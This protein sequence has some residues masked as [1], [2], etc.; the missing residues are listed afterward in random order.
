[1][2]NL[3]ALLG[4]E[5]SKALTQGLTKTATPIITQALTPATTNIITQAATPEIATS[6]SQLLPTRSGSAI[7]GVIN[8]NTG[9]TLPNATAKTFKDY[10]GS[11]DLASAMAEG[12]MDVSDLNALLPSKQ[13]NALRSGVADTVTMYS[14]EYTGELGTAAT[15]SSLPKIRTS[16]YYK[17]TGLKG[18]DVPSYMK[19]YLSEKNGVSLNDG[20]TWSEVFPDMAQQ[21]GAGSFAGTADDILARYEQ[22]SGTNA[23]DIYTPENYVN[24]LAL[25]PEQ[26]TE[27]TNSLT[28]LLGGDTTRIPVGQT[29]TPAQTIPV[30]GVTTTE[31]QTPATTAATDATKAATDTTS[32]ISPTTSTNFSQAQRNVAEQFNLSGAGAGQGGG[33]G[34]TITPASSPEDAGFNVPLKTE[35]QKT[36]RINASAA[37]TTAA[38][39]NARFK[40]DNW[41][42]GMNATSKQYAAAVKKSNSFGGYY[43]T[44]AARAQANNLN[45]ANIGDRVQ[46]MLDVRQNGVSQ[47]EQYATQQG[48]RV[49]LPSIELTQPQAQSLAANG[50]DVNSI[51]KS[52]TATP[53]EAEQIYKVLRDDGYRLSNA[54]DGTSLEKSRAYSEMA[55][56]VSSALNDTMD[57]LNIDYKTA[58]LQDAANI[59][60]DNKY[61]AEIA[62]APDF[63]F[64]D[65]RSDMADLMTL[66]D[67]AGNKLKNAKNINIAGIDTGIPNPATSLG[68]KIRGAYYNAAERLENARAGAGA[69]GGAGGAGTPAGD[70]TFTGGDGSASGLGN[71]LGG[72]KKVAPYALAAGIGFMAGKGGNGGSTGTLGED[73]T[74]L[75]GQGTTDATAQAVADPYQTTTIG[76]YTYQQLEDGYFNALMAGDTAAAN[77]IAQLLDVLQKRIERTTA[78]TSESGSN[79]TMSAGLNILNQLYG[80]YQQMGGAQ[81]VVGGNVTNAL[82][83]LSGGAYNADVATYNQTRALTSSMLARALGE[84]GTL[85]DTDRKY[86]NDNLPKVTDDPT[87]AEKKFR[88]IYNMLQTAANS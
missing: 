74:S 33:G 83:T 73:M 23:R 58:L 64:S 29:S 8:R 39:K 41:L 86:I 69:A 10:T 1:M 31:A 56:K 9:I 82:N 72:A 62:K 44:P 77:Q 49:N 71:L 85:S 4:S 38:Q 67:L 42:K 57:S 63:K 46:A 52:G 45:A 15:K 75:S 53:V 40:D 55:K 84:K 54:T 26:N 68:E 18:K 51:V 80:L 47:A 13:A 48:V 35:S 20:A 5:A 37:K 25:N 66:K 50:V 43:K 87:V 60:E 30:S 12:N 2:A 88:A 36:I 27:Y 21:G 34:I 65:L 61:L 70:Y 32:T 6:L 3:P 59:G 11:T 19:N 17:A 76:G 7:D 28:N 14:P 78:S 16:D 79:D 81:G 22:A 24:H